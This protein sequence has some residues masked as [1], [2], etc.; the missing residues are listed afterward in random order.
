VTAI[1]RSTAFV[2]FNSDLNAFDR[3][4]VNQT[5]SQLL[6]SETDYKDMIDVMRT[7]NSDFK[8]CRH[9]RSRWQ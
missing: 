9:T 4:A 2:Y 1:E 3:D 7:E 8:L 6:Y 5:D